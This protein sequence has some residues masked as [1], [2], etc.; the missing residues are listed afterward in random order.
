MSAVSDGVEPS[1]L[2]LS[3]CAKPLSGDEFN[4]NPIV[5]VNFGF[6]GRG[7]QTILL[8]A[9]RGA[10]IRIVGTE[11]NAT[12]LVLTRPGISPSGPP[13]EYSF[14]MV[15]GPA[16]S[17]FTL[18]V[19]TGPGQMVPIP[20]F[21]RRVSLDVAAYPSAIREFA[22]GAPIASIPFASKYE[23]VQI[24]GQAS[25]IEAPAVDGSLIFLIRP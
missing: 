16:D 9:L 25:V 17:E 3:V 4:F 12:P 13:L 24:L 11:V 14:T 6:A 8:D 23:S 21:A 19:P 1:L 15:Y 2:T 10:Q 22:G 7:K 5:R 18:T 20:S